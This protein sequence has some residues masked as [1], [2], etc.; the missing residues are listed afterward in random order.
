[1]LFEGTAG[2]FIQRASG[3]LAFTLTG[4]NSLRI[5]QMEGE[6]DEATRA[7][8]R[9][10]CMGATGI[11]PVQAAIS[12]AAQWMLWNPA[13]NTVT[14]FMDVIGSEALAGA[15]VGTGG[16]LY[17][18]PVPPKFAPA[19]IPTISQTNATIANCNPTSTRQ[20]NL[21]L[22]VSQTLLNAAAGNWTP[23]AFSNPNNTVL[24][25]TQV[26]HRD[27]RGK[28]C[29]PPGCGL[30]AGMVSPAGTGALWALY[31]QWREYAADLE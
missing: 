7:G 9:F 19:T 27:L 18:C 13:G 1:M 30:A 21:V 26:E 6:G 22:V 24:A 8:F 23:I 4:L 31:A 16:T 20:S 28:I 29:I 17:V 15:P 2:R 11:A 5:A 12:T 14:A 10:Q 3:L 25:Q